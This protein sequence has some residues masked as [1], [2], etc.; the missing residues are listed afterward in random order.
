MSGVLN[1]LREFDRFRLDL[2]TKVLWHGDE[3]VSL[4]GKAVEVLCRLVDRPGEVVTK[5]ELL[6]SVWPDSFVEESVLSQN[7]HHLRKAFRQLQFG[8]TAIQTIPRRGYRFTADVRAITSDVVLEHEVVDRSALFAEISA[9]S[10]R[11]LGLGT[12]PFSQTARHTRP[13]YRLP[14]VFASLILVAALA[15]AG[16]MNSGWAGAPERPTGTIGSLAVLPLK[17]LGGNEQKD[18][19]S[20][21]LT[22]SI[23][24]ELARLNRFGVRPFS[25]VERYGESGKDALAFGTELKV[26]SVLEGTIRQADDRLRVSLRLI[27]VRTGAQLWSENF[28]ETDADALKLQD[29]ISNR[30]ARAVL[31]TLSPREEALLAR[32]VTS[33]PEA[34]RLYLIGRERWLRR[35]P[36]GDSKAFFRRAIELDPHFALAY[37]GLAD[38]FVFDGN[39]KDAEGALARVI[40][41]EPDLGEAHATLGLMQ[42]FHHWDWSGAEASFRRAVQMAPNST[43]AHH[44]YG[45][46]LSLQGRH[47]EALEEMRRALELD[48][49]ALIIRSD[50]GELYYFKRD[51]DRAE[52]ELLTVLDSDPAFLKA[53]EYLIKVRFKKGVPYLLADAEYHLSV[54]KLHNP[55]GFSG[56]PDARE[57][58]RLVQERDEGA[59][60]AKALRDYVAEARRNP[61]NYLA[62]ARHFLIMGDEEKALYFLERSCD[63]KIT[64]LT[65]FVA[66]DPLW[67]PLRD[68]PRF[69]AI[70]RRIGLPGNG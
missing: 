63:A 47:D 3:P 43:K 26:D 29:S 25:A 34:Y 7:V 5:D 61:L 38:Q 13:G 27:D 53:R 42:M 67:D 44:W 55:D 32:P 68:K 59:L 16:L 69:K 8:G 9:D 70:L 62:F 48:P 2:R 18:V 20:L 15:A 50:I 14:L 58:E 23:I 65:S 12:H 22:D 21:G 37:L 46:Y 49:T 6:S 52:A 24:V 10:F 35:D 31:T 54:H 36:N 28:D 1:D 45:V 57:L 40:E 66:I 19:F 33:D 30:V 41:L 17:M 51:Y 4:P 11:E 56:D 64:L 60:R 39:Q